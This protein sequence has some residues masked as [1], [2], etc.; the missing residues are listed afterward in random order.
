MQNVQYQRELS[1]IRKTTICISNFT[2][3]IQQA[4]NDNSDYHWFLS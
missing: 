1:R 4:L 2:K 3:G